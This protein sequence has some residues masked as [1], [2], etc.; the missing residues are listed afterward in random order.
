M[1]VLYFLPTPTNELVRL[2]ELPFVPTAGL[3]VDVGSF[4]GAAT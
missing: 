1:T 3:M 2:G 4:S